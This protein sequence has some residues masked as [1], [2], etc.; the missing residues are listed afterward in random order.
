MVNVAARWSTQARSRRGAALSIRPLRPDDRQREIEFINGLSERS[1]YFRLFTP[2]KYLS[3]HLLDQLMDIDYRHR[4]AFVA[5]TQQDGVER[6]VGV[7][8]YGGS[9]QDDTAELAISVA[10]AW[11]RSGVARLLVNQ[12]IRYAREHGVRHLLGSV[13][14]DNH[15]MIAL[16]RRLAFTV[17]YDAAQHLFQISRDL[18]AA[19]TS[20]RCGE[21]WTAETRAAIEELMGSTRA[22]SSWD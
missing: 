22:V 19:E 6:F 13:L 9:G 16:S 5:T 17:S 4:M 2:L 20:Q 8:R 10:D 7:A 18:G 15:A 3:R 1:R 21:D 14:P 11:Q 12:L